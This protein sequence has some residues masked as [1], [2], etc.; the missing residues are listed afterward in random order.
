MNK[1]IFDVAIIGNGPAGSTVAL[2][3]SK[4]G[5]SAALFGL[6]PYA[7]KLFGETL[8]PEIK[9]ILCSM[10]I[11]S[12]FLSDGHLPSTG[13]ISSWGDEETKEHNF[14]FHPDTYG[15]HI[16]RVKFDRMLLK[17]AIKGGALYL[18]SVIEAVEYGC[19]GIW[20]LKLK[21]GQ[22]NRC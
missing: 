1:R 21:K 6:P 9:A 22:K 3:L 13:N 16:D 8:S 7:K 19:D 12:D 20:K 5:I 2:N 11:W 15:W 17:A 14:I 18:E 10:D 4:L